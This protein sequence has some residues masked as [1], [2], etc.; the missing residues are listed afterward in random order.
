MQE[1]AAR[2]EQELAQ[3]V[4]AA[5]QSISENVRQLLAKRF[6][7]QSLDDANYRKM[8]QQLDQLA[9]QV[10]TRSHEI[11]RKADRIMLGFRS[12]DEWQHYA[13][14]WATDFQAALPDYIAHLT[15]LQNEGRA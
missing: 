1:Q 7:K 3:Y 4:Q 9:H 6:E 15:A 5:Q 13:V 10:Q 12:K 8:Q 2:T 11:E 14:E